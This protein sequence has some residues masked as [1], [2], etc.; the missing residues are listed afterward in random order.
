MATILGSARSAFP[1]VCQ[2]M[3][4]VLCSA[5]SAHEILIWCSNCFSLG[6]RDRDQGL[7][8]IDSDEYEVHRYVEARGAK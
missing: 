2:A 6:R 7:Q 3:V 8:W 1:L 4:S 5:C